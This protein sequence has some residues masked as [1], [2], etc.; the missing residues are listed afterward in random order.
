[1][2]VSSEAGWCTSAVTWCS[3][4]PSK[5]GS[6]SPSISFTL[7]AGKRRPGRPS[8]VDRGLVGI[9][10]ASG[11][12]D[13][14][15]VVSQRAQ[16]VRHAPIIGMAPGDRRERPGDDQADLHARVLAAVIR[17]AVISLAG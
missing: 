15:H 3:G 7:S 14:L 9:G 2:P 13:H 17:D 1:M 6:A 10:Q 12:F 4:K 8:G 16:A 11:Q 5:A